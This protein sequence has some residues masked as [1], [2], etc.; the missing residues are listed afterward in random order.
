MP[1]NNYFLGGPPP[2][3]FYPVQ[4]QPV[5]QPITVNQS[6]PPNQQYYVPSAG[7]YPG[8]TVVVTS[9]PATQHTIIMTGGCP[10]CRVNI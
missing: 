5:F 6:I 9:Q 3:G 1:I 4:P 2:P 8:Q 10:V 7:Q